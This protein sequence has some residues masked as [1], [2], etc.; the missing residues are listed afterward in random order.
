MWENHRLVREI[1]LLTK[2]IVLLAINNKL[3]Q[4][5]TFPAEVC[6]VCRKSHVML[7]LCCVV[8]CIIL[9]LPRC[10]VCCGCV[11]AFFGVRLE[12]L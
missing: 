1:V 10:V 5:V 9:E 12:V 6:C 3:S 4:L 7:W 2:N 8:E 11:V